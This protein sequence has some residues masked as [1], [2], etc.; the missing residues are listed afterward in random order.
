MHAH[1]LTVQTGAVK[2]FHWHHWMCVTQV[3][4]VMSE[5]AIH[6]TR[7][8]IRTRAYT[9]IRIHRQRHTRTHTHTHTHTQ[10]TLLASL[11]TAI[12][13][14]PYET[15]SNKILWLLCWYFGVWIEWE[16][17][18][19]IFHATA[20]LENLVLPWVRLA[21]CDEWGYC[22]SILDNT[23]E[24]WRFPWLYQV[25]KKRNAFSTSALR[26]ILSPRWC[27]P[28][29]HGPRVLR[30]ASKTARLQSSLSLW[31]TGKSMGRQILNS[32]RSA[33]SCPIHKNKT[34]PYRSVSFQRYF[35]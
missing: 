9:H 12:C 10:S 13:L 17:G 23:W 4:P 16:S 25:E 27:Q 22:L 18:G 34:C 31:W 7:L 26:F 21:V 2:F 32:H 11:H 5:N 24:I 1:T 3:H 28:V 30:I 14:P 29:Q 15:F 6:C 19:S 20:P 33:V 8:Y 35:G